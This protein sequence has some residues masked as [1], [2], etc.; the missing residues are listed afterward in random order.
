MTRYD[1]MGIL[2]MVPVRNGSWVLYSEVERAA[3]ARRDVV[4]ML[5]ETK[6]EN[7]RLRKLVNQFVREDLERK[8]VRRPACSEP[9]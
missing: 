1:N 3:A 6:E 7:A 9:S 2:G 8:I 5:K 4:A